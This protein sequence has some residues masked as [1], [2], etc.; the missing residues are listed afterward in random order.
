[1]LKVKELSI[2]R[3]AEPILSSVSFEVKR[4]EVVAII[5]PNGSGKTSLLKALTGSSSETTGEIRINSFNVQGDN[6]KAKSQ[7]GYLPNPSL[8]E[9]YLTGME[10]L[11]VVGSMYHLSPPHRIQR[12]LKYAET[13]D[14]KEQLFSL[15]EQAESSTLQ[16]VGIVASIIHQPELVIWDE[17]TQSLDHSM[18]E[19]LLGL[20][21]DL[22]AEGSAF[23]I[24]TNDLSWAERVADR[25]MLVGNGELLASGTLNELHNQYRTNKSLDSIYMAAF[26]EH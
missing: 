23:L 22:S 18:K 25:F 12:I 14:F 26:N 17:P 19:Q 15:N 5:G 6:I 9:P 11:E 7:F 2:F 20:V 16:K 24:A 4:G 10:W 1:M 8:Y 21:K 13:L 3:K